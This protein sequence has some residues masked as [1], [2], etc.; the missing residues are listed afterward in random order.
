M[1]VVENCPDC[2]QKHKYIDSLPNAKIS[3]EQIQRIHDSDGI[4]FAEPI[5][6]AFGD[7]KDFLED[8]PVD[9]FV[10]ATE[11]KVMFVQLTRREHQNGWVI[12]REVEVDGGDEAF[13]EALRMKGEMASHVMSGVSEI[14][15]FSD[16]EANAKKK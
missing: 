5:I 12:T 3:R 4:V 11:S 2:G 8:D 10:L 9:G 7:A 16:H 14:F 15:G 6:D 1:R 13:H